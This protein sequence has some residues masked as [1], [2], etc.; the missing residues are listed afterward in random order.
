VS[1]ALAEVAGWGPFFAVGTHPAGAVPRPP[2]RPM[3]ELVADPG[4][5]AGR[6]AA[7]RAHLAAG[8]GQDPDR[9]PPRVA[10]SVTQLGLVARLLSP[11]LA[12][13]VRGGPG[14]GP[15]W[16][17]LWWQPEPGSLFPLSVPA[18]PAGTPERVIDGPVRDLVRLTGGFGVSPRVLWGNVASAVNGAV[19][20]IGGARPELRPR[21]VAVASAL[22]DR[23]PLRHTGDGLAEGR[24][25]RRSCCLIYRAAPGAGRAA[26]CGD[27]V[28]GG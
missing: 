27:C 24:F 28:L 22:L 5:L 18:D 13:A 16:T 23:P 15:D 14:F 11:A 20:A 4:V 7:V 1:A 2:W 21:A 9:V 17:G 12:C 25:R 19:T 3:R 10:A 8:T 26:V 6:V